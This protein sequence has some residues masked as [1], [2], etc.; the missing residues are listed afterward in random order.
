MPAAPDTSAAAAANATESG[1]PEQATAASVAL[2]DRMDCERLTG[3]A[4]TPGS[5]PP[6]VQVQNGPHGSRVLRGY[7]FPD[8]TPKE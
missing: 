3:V 7:R 5:K 1:P 6:Y 4:A 2:L 8:L